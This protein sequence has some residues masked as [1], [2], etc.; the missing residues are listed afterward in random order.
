MR[1]PDSSPVLGMVKGSSLNHARTECPLWDEAG[2][3]ESSA[4]SWDE[5]LD[6]DNRE[7]PLGEGGGVGPGP[8]P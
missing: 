3:R 2:R 6:H 4:L 8:T 5:V 1:K 7:I